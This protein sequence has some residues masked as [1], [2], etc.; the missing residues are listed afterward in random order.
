MSTSSRKKAPYT[1]CVFFLIVIG[2]LLDS[3][4]TSTPLS[5]NTRASSPARLRSW[6]FPVK[7]VMLRPSLPPRPIIAIP[8]RTNKFRHGS[9]SESIVSRR[10]ASTYPFG[11]FGGCSPRWS[12]GSCSLARSRRPECRGHV[13]PRLSQRATVLRHRG[14]AATR[15]TAPLVS[16]RHAT[17]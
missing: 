4:V 9:T 7:N 6:L 11:R 3:D 13:L 5:L 8:W 1:A 16:C 15:P 12:A 17:R 14:I 2:N 10:I